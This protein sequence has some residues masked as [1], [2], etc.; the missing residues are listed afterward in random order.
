MGSACPSDLHNNFYLIQCLLLQQILNILD[1]PSTTHHSMYFVLIYA[2]IT[3]EINIFDLHMKGIYY[4]VKI[5]KFHF[6]FDKNRRGKK[7]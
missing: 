2:K 3:M 1:F 6:D 7:I 5:K 4:F